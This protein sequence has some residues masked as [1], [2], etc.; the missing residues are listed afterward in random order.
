MLNFAAQKKGQ[1]NLLPQKIYMK[2]ALLSESWFWGHM[3]WDQVCWIWQAVLLGKSFFLGAEDFFACSF[4][5]FHL[6]KPN[7]VS[8]CGDCSKEVSF[9]KSLFWW[10]LDVCFLRYQSLDF[11]LRGLFVT[12]FSQTRRTQTWSTFWSGLFVMHHNSIM[13]VGTGL[14]WFLSW[15]KYITETKTRF[16]FENHV[17]FYSKTNAYQNNLNWHSWVCVGPSA[18]SPP[19][20]K[21]NVRMD[22][23]SNIAPWI[24]S[25][26]LR[27]GFTKSMCPVSL[28]MWGSISGLWGSIWIWD[29]AP[30]KDFAKQVQIL[31]CGKYWECM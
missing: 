2:S 31:K 14:V 18:L 9:F 30:G 7:T 12:D 20:H 11:C 28:S 19:P 16:P 6:A 15:C 26:H 23:D 17:W 13:P 27:A 3:S 5:C 24:K 21:N 4:V 22:L 10:P 1:A 8:H 29:S 25:K